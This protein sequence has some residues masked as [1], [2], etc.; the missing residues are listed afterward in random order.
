MEIETIRHKALK[1]YTETG[2]AKGLD[3][4]LA[5][6][7]RSMIAFLAIAQ[8]VDDL[9]IPPN[10]GFHWLTGNRTGIAAMTLTK[11]WRMTFAINDDG[12]II[13]LD[14]EDYH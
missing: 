1:A 7:V 9:H 3:A 8:D 4:R 2:R 14:L 10:F 6:R 12:K 13:D 11:N 5:G